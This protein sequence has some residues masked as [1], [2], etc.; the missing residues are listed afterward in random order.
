MSNKPVKYQTD[1]NTDALTPAESAELA[2]LAS[3]QD[4]E[5]DYSDIPELKNS[6]FKEAG[7]GRLY[8]PRKTLTSVRIDA[9]VLLWL[10]GEDATGYQTRLNAI[11]R[12]AMLE[13]L[14][15]KER[16]E[17]NHN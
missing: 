14:E 6:Y 8:R 9:D 13:A 4:A 17:P 1:M 16:T 11:L 2:A 15:R 3:K 12:R 7:R 5:I 10:R